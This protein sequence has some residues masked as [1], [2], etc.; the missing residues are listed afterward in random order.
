MQL[1]NA[2]SYEKG[3]WVLHMLRRKLGDAV[4]QRGIQTYY[5]TYKGSN[6]S[7]DDFMDI[8][9]KVSKQNLQ[10]F[11][12]QW[13]YTAGQPELQGNWKYDAKAKS[14]EITITQKQDFVF[15]ICF[16]NSANQMCQQR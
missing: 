8:M 14:L 2:N 7:T 1:L 5:A 3:S 11:F 12:K 15:Q 10:I 13:L 4:F 16:G 6:A 9:G